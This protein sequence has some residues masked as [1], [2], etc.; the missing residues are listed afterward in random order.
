MRFQV[1]LLCILDEERFD[2]LV[3]WQHDWERKRKVRSNGQ[4]VASFVQ[5]LFNHLVLKK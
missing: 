3:N 2:S 5:S 4:K 1:F